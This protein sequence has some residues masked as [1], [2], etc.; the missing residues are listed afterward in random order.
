MALRLLLCWSVLLTPVGGQARA[1]AP[2]PSQDSGFNVQ[3]VEA[4]LKQRVEKKL[5]RGIAVALIAPDG[6]IE[7]V[8]AGHSGNASRAAVDGDTLFEIGSITKVFTATLLAQMVEEGKVKLDSKV[9]DVLPQRNWRTPG[10]GDVTL[11]QLT[12]HTSGLPRL[13][14]EWK[15]TSSML[16]SIRNP[17]ANYSLND[18]WTYVQNKEHEAK[19]D[20]PS[21]Y[22]NLGVG[23]L[24]E[25][26]AEKEGVSFEALVERRILKPLGMTWSGVRTASVREA[27]LAVGHSTSLSPQPYWDIPSLQGAG[28]LRSSVSEMAKFIHAQMRGTLAGATATQAQRVKSSEQRGVGMGWAISRKHNDE[29]L[30][31]NGGT[32]GFRTFAGFSRVS[33]KGVVVL[34]NA[35]ID[36]DDIGLHLLNSEFKLQDNPKRV[37]TFHVILGTAFGI[38]MILR[39]W[40]ATA[41]IRPVAPVASDASQLA[42]VRTLRDKFVDWRA[43]KRIESRN[44]L[45]WMVVELTGMIVL[46]NLIG[47][48]DWLAVEWRMAYLGIGGALLAWTIWK[49]RHLPWRDPAPRGSRLE[50][51]LER[52]VSVFLLGLIVWNFM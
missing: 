16:L 4:I 48:W 1:A 35:A 37:A 50:R 28:A 5:T 49:L 41:P 19:N 46:G 51:Y 9:R 44:G 10:V 27:F 25:V 6:K 31:H 42:K 47:L 30:W 36:T 2:A 18:M 14:D 8:T 7:I 3:D 29:L 13:P 12:T 11:L 40:F 45:F 15:F 39:T 43:K 52:V 22:S 24:G 26:L 33:G 38:A 32:G 21:E 23:L 17:Y 20:Y 34:S